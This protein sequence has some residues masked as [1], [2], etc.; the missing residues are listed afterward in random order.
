V[1]FAT[2]RLGRRANTVLSQAGAPTRSDA[3]AAL[4]IQNQQ[5]LGRG[6]FPDGVLDFWMPG[7]AEPPVIEGNYRVIGE[8]VRPRHEPIFNNWRNAIPLIAFFGVRFL[9]ILATRRH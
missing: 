1:V 4:T 5:L 3:P 8:T 7:K 9:F 6:K 2:G